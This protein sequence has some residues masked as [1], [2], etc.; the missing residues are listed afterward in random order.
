MNQV[1]PI[2]REISNYSPLD[3]MLAD[4]AVR[5]QLT[6]TEHAQAEGHYHTLHEWLNRDE[7]PL[8]GL[9]EN[10]YAQGGF[11]IGATTA[12]HA[13]DADFDI[14]A[15]AQL[16]LQPTSDPEAVLDTLYKSIKGKPGSRYWEKTDRKTRCV[17]VLY[18]GSHL[19]ITPAVLAPE[20]EERTSYIFHSKKLETGFDKKTLIANPYG[21]AEW[22]KARTM[23]DSAFGHF[24]ERQALAYDWMRREVLGADAEPV[25]E[26]APAY[27]K[28]RAVISLQLLKRWRNIAYDARHPGRR[29]PPSVVLAHSVALNANRTNS[30]S[31][32]LIHQAICLI[33]ALEKAESEGK[34]YNVW[35][36]ACEKDDRLTDR[37]PEDLRAQRVFI[38]ELRAF[39]VDMERLQKGLP[40][41][42]IRKTLERLFG[43]RP[44]NDAVRAFMDRHVRDNDS[45]RAVHI[46]STGSVPALGSLATP[47]LARPT[48]KSSPFGD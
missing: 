27:R 2:L 9:V 7:S 23:P 16:S 31:E 39:V 33:V 24:F 12:R 22:F 1:D 25:P 5:V 15:M 38:D 29:L 35:N 40:L 32:E 37:W 30:L 26:Q 43:E 10:F 11:A 3:V 20:R 36:P 14:D 44:A 48:P 18:E 4:V 28:S 8:Q 6:P 13:D 34:T 21:F 45:N 41:S 47:A 17:T 42:E 19:D 46:I